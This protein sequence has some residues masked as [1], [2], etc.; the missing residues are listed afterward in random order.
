M[1]KARRI[2]GVIPARGGSKD[3][4]RKNIRPLAG[5][6]L[7]AY[8]IAAAR[9]SK[10]LTSFLVSTE[11]DEI[12]RI[13]REL[14]APVPFTRPSELAQDWSEGIDV[15]RHALAYLQE[16]HNEHYDYVMVLQPTSPLRTVDDIDRCIEKIVQTDSDSVMSMVELVDFAPKK[17]K[18]IC[19]DLIL[20][21]FEDEGRTTAARHSLERVYRRNCAIYLTRTELVL[22][23][24][25]FGKISRPYLMPPERSVDINTVGDF[26][27]AEF[28]LAAPTKDQ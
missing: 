26:A 18:R 3:V 13:A 27:L 23:G 24:D 22:Q 7:I 1:Y 9:A 8:T 17:L 12:A 20:P 25:L 15:T 28:Y 21:L 19:D 2:L 10:L 16:H 5:K 14:G 11:D 6:P 4:P